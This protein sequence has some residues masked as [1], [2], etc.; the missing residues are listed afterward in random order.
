MMDEKER[1]SRPNEGEALS[2]ERRG[3]EGP[4][5]YYSRERRLSRAPAPVRALYEDPGK[6]GFSLL[7]PLISS[8]P[9]AVLFGTVAALILITLVMSFSGVI[10]GK[11]YRG[12]RISLSAGRYGGA[13]LVVLK[14]TITGEEAYTGPLSLSVSPLAGAGVSGAPAYP[15]RVFFSSRKTEE[16]RFSVPFDEPELLIELSA[17]DSEKG[18][19]LVFKIK[20]N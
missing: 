14:K 3:E 11:V 12:S 18:D 15:H 9:N 19:S 7:R 2:E 1:P 4:Q 5:F 13:V 20:T 8:K 17:G 10:G 16:F 6:P